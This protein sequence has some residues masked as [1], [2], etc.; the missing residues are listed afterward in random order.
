DRAADFESACGGSTPPGATQGVAAMPLGSSHAVRGRAGYVGF[1]V[2]QE[3]V[4]LKASA[5]EPPASFKV[6]TADFASLTRLCTCGASKDAAAVS[7]A[8]DASSCI[9]PSA[10]CAELTVL[11]TSLD[12]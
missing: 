1:R 12:S 5:S 3:S 8:T 4:F 9:W 6:P 2:L 7:V 10:L 11:F